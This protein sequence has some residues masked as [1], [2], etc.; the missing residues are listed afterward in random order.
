VTLKEYCHYIEQCNQDPIKYC[1]MC[2]AV[3]LFSG[4]PTHIFV[5]TDV[6]R[7]TDET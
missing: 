4:I 1:Y 7:T 5:T 6:I 2:C 3:K